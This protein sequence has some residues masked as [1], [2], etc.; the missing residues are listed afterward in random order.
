MKQY[1]VYVNYTV[2]CDASGYML[3]E[4]ESEDEAIEV[5][6]NLD[7]EIINVSL[8]EREVVGDIDIEDIKQS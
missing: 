3:I 4:A 2:E 5:A 1:K 8:E 6:S 7:A